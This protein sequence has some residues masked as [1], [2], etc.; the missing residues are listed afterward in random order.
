MDDKDREILNIVNKAFP[1][2]ERPYQKLSESLG[3]SE[4]EIQSR[5]TALKNKG[6]IRRI[7]ATINASKLGYYSTLCAADVP[8]GKIDAFARL[9]NSY[10]EIT[11]NYIR[12][13]SP[14]CWFT[15]IAADKNRCFEII[16]K[17]KDSL[18]LAVLSLPAKKI[19]KIGVSFN[20]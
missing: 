8:A 16:D 2:T 10:S 6:L 18:G 11:H 4:H 7:G 20:L 19:Y 1:L 9:A 15:I 3:L 13:G 12:E 14:N 5:I 17:F